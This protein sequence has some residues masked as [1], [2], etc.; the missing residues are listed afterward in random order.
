[1][2]RGKL[3][4][5]PKNCP[6]AKS[7]LHQ[8]SD[9]AHVN[10]VVL[11]GA[12]EDG[13][14]CGCPVWSYNVSD[15]FAVHHPTIAA[16]PVDMAKRQLR[17]AALARQVDSKRRRPRAAAKG[18]P[19]GPALPPPVRAAAAAP[20]GAGAGAG[21][22]AD[23]AEEDEEED[24][25][26]EGEEGEGEED[27]GASALIVGFSQ[28]DVVMRKNGG[29][30]GTVIDVYFAPG[31][32]PAPV[33]GAAKPKPAPPVLAYTVRWDT[34]AKV[35]RDLAGAALEPKPQ[36]TRRRVV[37]SYAALAGRRPP[38]APMAGAAGGAGA[39]AGAGGRK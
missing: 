18:A 13:E 3:R 26:E 17:A 4:Y 15:H 6:F 19:V 23:A 2:T 7:R 22:G 32:T 35:E 38:A 33:A 34:D 36:G 1:M 14:Q 16:P 21:G 39:G 12:D 25:D 27:A 20:A 5:V 28:S 30:L 8:Y 10:Q 11:C 29:G 37:Q 31:A 9:M 24:D